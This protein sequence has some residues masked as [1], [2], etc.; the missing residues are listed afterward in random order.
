ISGTS[1][2]SSRLHPH[3]APRETNH[4]SNLAANDDFAV[5]LRSL[6]KVVQSL[7]CHDL[8]L[9]QP[10]ESAAVDFAKLAVGE[11]T[12][13]S[14]GEHRVKPLAIPGLSVVESENLFGHVALQMERSDMD[15]SAP[16]HPLGERPEV[17]QPVRVNLP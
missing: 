17:L 8:L 14:R 9:L 13:G 10:H 5:V 2:C 7:C 15:V 16:D 11:A 6:E 4:L 1:V 3:I 12:P